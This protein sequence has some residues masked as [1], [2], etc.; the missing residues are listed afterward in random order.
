VLELPVTEFERNSVT[1]SVSN[2]VLT[3]SLR[4]YFEAGY[5]SFADEINSS[6]HCCPS[7]AMSFLRNR[8]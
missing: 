3:A 5:S 2:T 4:C 7:V 8:A 6:R 1:R